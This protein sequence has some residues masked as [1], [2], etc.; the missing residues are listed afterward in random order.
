MYQYTQVSIDLCIYAKTWS[1]I[2]DKPTSQESS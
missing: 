1:L 2:K